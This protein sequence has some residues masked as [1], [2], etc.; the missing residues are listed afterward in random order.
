MDVNSIDQSGPIK[1][2]FK[3]TFSKL[4][5]RTRHNDGGHL[6]AKKRESGISLQQASKMYE[7]RPTNVP[8]SSEMQSFKKKG[9]SVSDAS[10]I[11]NFGNQDVSGRSLSEQVY[12]NKQ[13]IKPKKPTTN[14]LIDPIAKEEDNN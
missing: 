7:D 12:D 1:S 9:L 5:K 6:K 3:N 8:I 2:W 11:S 13:G 4:G 14:P 10:A